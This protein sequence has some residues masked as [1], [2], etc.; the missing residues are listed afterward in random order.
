MRTEDLIALMSSSA[1]PVDT[2]RLRRAVWLAA[3]AALALTVV[4]V[5]S[6]LGAR[7]DMPGA[8]AAFPVLAKMSFGASV[9]GIS[10]VAYQRSLYP[11]SSPRP[12][13]WWLAIPAAALAA[14]A[15]WT[16]F[17]AAPDQW[18]PLTFGRYWLSCLIAVPVYSLCPLAVLVLLARRGAPVDR[19]FTAFAAGLASAG[20]A[21]MAYALHCPDD[22]LPFLATWYVLAVAMVSV[23]ATLALPS[24]LRW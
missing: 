7:P 5:L 24:F 13:L 21:A 16:L 12:G 17:Q 3:F 22:A 9:A 23:V 20:L 15:L 4:L 8:L 6:T 2:G 1:R 14:M 11:G 10:L 18:G 19:R